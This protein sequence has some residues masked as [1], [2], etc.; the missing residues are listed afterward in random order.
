MLA[1]GILVGLGTRKRACR[2]DELWQF[3]PE[4]IRVSGQ[5]GRLEAGV[6]EHRLVLQVC[7]L[8][9]LQ[10][11]VEAGT[12]ARIRLLDRCTSMR[13]LASLAVFLD[14][15]ENARTEIWLLLFM[16]AMIV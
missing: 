9:A 3:L 14:A 4:G 10:D 5:Q 8:P 12:P 13:L 6:V 16:R 2:C 7:D 15:A 11:K 1:A